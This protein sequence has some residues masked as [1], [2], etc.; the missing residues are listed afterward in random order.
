MWDGVSVS[1]AFDGEM[2]LDI[3]KSKANNATGTG[4]Y[5]QKRITS[6]ML[7]SKLDFWPNVR[8]MSW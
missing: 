2:N 3:N 6:S 8:R 5:D 7:Q 1:P 4:E